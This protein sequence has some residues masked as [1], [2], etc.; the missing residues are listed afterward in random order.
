MSDQPDKA[1][2]QN[3]HSPAV[4]DPTDAQ[5]TLADTATQPMHF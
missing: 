1:E 3:Q 4:V 5:N 2:T